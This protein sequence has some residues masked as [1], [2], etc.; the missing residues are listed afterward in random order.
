MKYV[1]REMKIDQIIS[2]LNEGKIRLTPPFQRGSVWTLKQ[3]QDLLSNIVRVRPIP[4]VFLYRQESGAMY[5]YNILDGKQRLESL[6][7]FVGDRRKDLK[8]ARMPEFFYGK[9]A[10]LKSK[11]FKVQ[12][13]GR[14]V[15]FV[16][17]P[18]DRMRTFRDFVIPTVEIDL[19]DDAS[20]IDDVIQLFIDINISGTKVNRF[21]VIK[22]MKG[23]RTIFSQV[24]DLVA[25]E[26]IRQKT[27]YYRAKTRSVYVAVLKNLAVV[28]RAPDANSKVD[29]MW[30]RLTE[31]ALFVATPKHK[32]PG[33]ILRSFIEPNQA[34]D[35][36]LTKQQEA[37]LRSVFSFLKWLYS[38]S[39]FGASK[40]AT[41]QP[42]FYTLTTTLLSSDWIS[43][44]GRD[45]LVECLQRFRT[46]LEAGVED[47]AREWS[48][49]STKQT[50]NP[51]RRARRQELLEQALGSKTTSQ[52]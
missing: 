12:L 2:Y 30:E 16:D 18:D 4:A 17:L 42:Q 51:G 50:T 47:A 1:N 49:L 31:I 40:L 33:M 11:N 24:F 25:I 10:T 13:D 39:N 6:M 41:D 34:Q 3:R 46:M 35:D 29:R 32:T 37:V 9:P 28:N 27:N 14:K 22:A 21:D 7:L 44:L 48:D 26:Q 36:R 52:S 20:G 45:G 23:R 43:R 38:N 15:G 19:D 8:V 5:S